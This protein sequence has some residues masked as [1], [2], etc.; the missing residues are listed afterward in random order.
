VP[1]DCAL[2]H[3]MQEAVVKQTDLADGKQPAS[4]IGVFAV[5][6]NRGIEPADAVERLAADGEVSTVEHRH[7]W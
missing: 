2:E 6:F 3:G 5:E 1:L 7:Q 4:E